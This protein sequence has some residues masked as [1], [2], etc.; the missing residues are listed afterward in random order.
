MKAEKKT[1][2]NRFLLVLG[3]GGVSTVHA[4]LP[5][6]RICTIAKRRAV[7]KCDTRNRRA[8]R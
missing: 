5:S 6:L 8:A 3:P 4:K 2:G 1:E 7:E